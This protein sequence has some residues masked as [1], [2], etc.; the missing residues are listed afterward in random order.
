MEALKYKIFPIA[1][2]ALTVSFGNRISSDLNE[3]VNQLSAQIESNPIP[4]FIECAPAYSSLTVFFD[5]LAAKRKFRSSLT[6]FEIVKSL[7]EIEIQKLK[8]TP[9]PAHQ[10][11]EIPVSF[12]REHAPDLEF[13]AA[14][15]DLNVVEVKEIF[16]GATY[17]VFMLG[18]LPGFPYMGEVDQKI[19]TPRKEIPRE[20]VAKGS[21]GI[22]GTQTGI[23]PLESPGGWQ[24]IGRTNV[25]LFTPEKNPPSYLNPGDLIKFIES[26]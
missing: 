16:L 12:E 9:S 25:Q 13:V 19:A 22:A 6:A 5:L 14:A 18:F 3:L 1:E 8:I 21:V 15:N 20:R 17:R 4:G 26:E 2:D 7:I 10:V 24:I 23:Y 11:I